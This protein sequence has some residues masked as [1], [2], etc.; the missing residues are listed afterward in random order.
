MCLFEQIDSEGLS[1]SSGRLDAREQEIY[2]RAREIFLSRLDASAT[3]KERVKNIFN[4]VDELMAEFLGS[5][6]I[7]CH[8]GCSTCCYQ[9]ICCTTLEMELIVDYLASLSRQARHNIIQRVNKESRWLDRVAR[10]FHSGSLPSRWEVLAAGPLREI[11][12]GKRPCPFLNSLGE[13]SI[14]PARPI[15]CRIARSQDPNCGSK[16]EIE[17][18]GPEEIIFEEPEAVRLYLDQVA[19][20][21]VMEEEE[22]VKGA[23]QLVPLSAWTLTPDFRNFFVDRPQQQ[24]QKSSKK[25]HKKR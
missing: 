22:K 14:Y 25:K 6:Q 9:L 3:G 19:S 11:Y 7:A 20:D 10:K 21:L 24:K 13:C 2:D 12:Y 17:G 16:M 15:D 5:N 8:C 23:M 18:E 4:L 1:L